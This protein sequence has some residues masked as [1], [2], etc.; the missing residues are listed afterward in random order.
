MDKIMKAKKSSS[1]SMNSI[2]SLKLFSITS[3]NAITPLIE[4]NVTLAKEWLLK[5]SKFAFPDYDNI[6][7]NIQDE[8]E[9]I[10]AV[11]LPDYS[12][13]ESLYLDASEEFLDDGVEIE[14]LKATA[15]IEE[16]RFVMG[17]ARLMKLLPFSIK[18][19]FLLGLYLINEE[20]ECKR[21]KGM[22]LILAGIQQSLSKQLTLKEKR[23]AFEA[24][25]K[26][27]EHILLK[28]NQDLSE[29]LNRICNTISVVE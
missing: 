28:H 20:N 12:S 13:G 18:A 6:V 16:G 26:V 19:R 17:S 9:K 24:V 21:T 7:N 3:N 27:K 29:S 23:I 5:L 14:I 8:W 4:V 11:D 2:K 25:E 15:E 1:K 10:N 22:V